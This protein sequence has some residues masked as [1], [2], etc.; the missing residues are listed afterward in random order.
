M[1]KKT[2]AQAE[3]SLD[4]ATNT[5]EEAISNGDITAEEALHNL[6]EAG[7]AFLASFDAKKTTGKEM[8]D[9]VKQAWESFKTNMEESTSVSG[10]KDELV[11]KL[12]RIEMSWQEYLDAEVYSQEGKKG[13]KEE[14]AAA[15]EQFQRAL[16]ESNQ[17]T[18]K[19]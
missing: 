17:L 2:Q 19:F 7:K 5:L 15:K 16:T 10:T 18:L 11:G 13:A 1:A 12:R 9:H 6:R 8:A 4:E 14:H 3:Q